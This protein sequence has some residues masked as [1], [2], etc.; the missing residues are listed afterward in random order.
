MENID[1]DLVKMG[2]HAK[3]HNSQNSW[4]ILQFVYPSNQQRVC[5]TD[6]K[7]SEMLAAIR[8]SSKVVPPDRLQSQ[9][10]RMNGN[11]LEM[12]LNFTKEQIPDRQISLW[13]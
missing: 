13:K 4:L 10:N 1:R 9:T 11:G 6:E 5:C 3:A 12:A 2:T 7:T 8:S